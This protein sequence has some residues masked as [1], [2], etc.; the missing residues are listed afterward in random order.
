MELILRGN[1]IHCYPIKIFLRLLIM[2][3]WFKLNFLENGAIQ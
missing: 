1:G 2:L 3:N